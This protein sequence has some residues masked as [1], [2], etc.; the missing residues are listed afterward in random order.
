M[1]MGAINVQDRIA[2]SLGGLGA[3]SPQLQSNIDVMNGGVLFALPALLLNGLLDQTEKHF[4]LPNGYYGAYSIFLLLAFAALARYKSVEALRH[5]P[6]GEWGKLIGLD[7]IPEARTLRE[8]IDL[9]TQNHQSKEWGANLCRQ[10]MINAPADAATIYID[11]HVRVYNGGQTNLPR[12]Y[13]AREKLCARGVCDYWA[14]SK[15][16][17]PF[18]YITKPVDPGLVKVLEN[19]IVPELERLIPNQPSQ[20][21]LQAHP[22]KHR[23][24]LA[25]DR[26]GFSTEFMARMATRRIACMTYTK[27]QGD[28]WEPEEFLPCTMVLPSG[29]I[30]ECK[31]AERG[32]LKYGTNKKPLIWVRE[33]RRVKKNHSQGS[34]TTTNYEIDKVS[35]YIDIISRWCQENFFSYMRHHFNIDRLIEHSLSDLDD[36]TNVIN[37]KWRSIDSE[38]RKQQGVLN[39]RI[40]EFGALTLDCNI[41]TKEFADKQNEKSKLLEEIEALENLIKEKKLERK[42]FPKRVCFSDL[43]E[44][45]KFKQPRPHAKHFI[46]TIKMI[47]YRAETCMLNTVREKMPAA[48]W[49]SSRAVVRGIYAS[50]ADFEVNQQDKT[51]TIKLHHQASDRDDEAIKFLCSELTETETIYPGTNLRLIY[52]MVSD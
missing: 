48:T 22:K 33:I 32:V 47:A 39:R 31:I 26:A 43:P 11:G 38:I 3:V 19:D 46:D 41:E 13:V 37:P 51:L 34:M 15:D 2:S 12:H 18:F 10:W 30:K 8:K 42:T 23:F 5:V 7:R 17:K 35:A 9:L 29:E 50:S 28:D 21:E 6:P 36:T 1:G 4:Q 52:K 14:N 27:K 49:D 24:T 20:E 45:A 44:E 25:F 16:G 40:A